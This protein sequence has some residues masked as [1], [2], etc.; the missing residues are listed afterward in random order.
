MKYQK[1]AKALQARLDRDRKLPADDWADLG[2]LYVRLGEPVSAVAVLRAAQRACP[3]HFAIAANLGIAWQLAGDLAQAAGALQQAVRLAPGKQLLA[4]ELHL[5]LVRL[6]LKQQGA[7]Q[8]LDDLFGIHYGGAKGDY[9]P[10]RLGDAERKKLP[11][12]AIALVQQLGLWL[13]AD[14]PLLWQL[15][16]LAGRMAISRAPR[17]W[18]MAASC[19]SA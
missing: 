2:A 10:G 1:A 13:P 3:N 7:S 17:R 19:S 14:G 9:Q 12:R 15:A 4:E 6:R 5:K 8:E 18:R 11:D 16:E